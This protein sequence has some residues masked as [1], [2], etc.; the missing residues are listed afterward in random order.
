MDNQALNVALQ[1][2]VLQQ[3]QQQAQHAHIVQI[4]NQLAN[5]AGNG[6]GLQA[7][8]PALEPKI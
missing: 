1:A 4:L 8:Y 5:G 3:Q 2:I 6:D 7:T